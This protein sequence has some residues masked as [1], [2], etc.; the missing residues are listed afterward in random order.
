MWSEGVACDW[1]P[2]P[3]ERTSGGMVLEELGRSPAPVNLMTMGR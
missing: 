2:P 3:Q 1:I